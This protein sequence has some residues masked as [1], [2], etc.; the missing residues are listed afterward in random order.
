MEII[1][2][3]IIISLACVGLRISSSKGMILYF[4]RKPYEW[5][6]SQ[7]EVKQTELDNITTQLNH[8]QEKFKDVDNYHSVKEKAIMLKAEKRD[9]KDLINIYN[10]LIYILK[11][12]IGC[13]TCFASVYSVIISFFFFELTEV[14]I[15]V[16]FIVSCLNSIIFALYT[17]L[18]R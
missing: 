11:P 14:T 13:V 9:A 16:I 1:I 7:V 4:F 6:Q 15:L 8:I 18:I 10:I 12:F 3:S 2:Q 5:M 17:K